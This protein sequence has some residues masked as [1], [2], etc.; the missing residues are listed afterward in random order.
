MCVASLKIARAACSFRC[1]CNVFDRGKSFFMPLLA[2]FV[3]FRLPHFP[4]AHVPCIDHGRTSTWAGE[5][6]VLCEHVEVRVRTVDQQAFLNQLIA[7]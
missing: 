4:A 1:R 2:G 6:H 5:R 3:G 7:E